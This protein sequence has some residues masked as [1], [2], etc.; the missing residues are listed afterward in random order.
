MRTFCKTLIALSVG[1]ALS[2]SANAA[3]DVLTVWEDNNKAIGIEQAARDFAKENR[4]KVVI[5]QKESTNHLTE[6]EKLT[7]SG[8]DVPD[9]FIVISDRTGEAVSKKVISDLPFMKS[10]S[11][12]YAKLATDVFHMNGKYYAAPRSIE[13]LVVYYNKDLLEVPYETIDGYEQAGDRLASQGKYG[14]VGK[15][16]E[17]YIGYGMMAAYGGYVFGKNGDEYNKFDVGFAS[18]NAAD[19]LSNLAEYVR[20][21]IPKQLLTADGWGLVDKMF[22][23]GQ[24]AAVINGPWALDSYAKSGINYGIAPLPKLKNGEYFR[25]FYGVKGYAIASKSQNKDLAARFIEFINQPKY[26]LIRYSA[27]AELPPINDVIANPLI[28][29]DDFSNALAS[30]MLNAD[31]MPYITETSQIWV[32]MGDAIKNVINKKQEANKA[33]HEAVVKINRAI[34]NTGKNQEEDTQESV[35]E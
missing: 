30:Q 32:P 3:S 5:E 12:K 15:L 8:G 14:L 23:E 29:N 10:D 21:Y 9:V 26:A 11:S 6:V 13:T 34:S 31:A 33:L 28:A 35:S 4:V 22:I 2:Q 20:R 24:V 1:V 16:D 27:I 18:G 19:G 7:D 25:P 17:L